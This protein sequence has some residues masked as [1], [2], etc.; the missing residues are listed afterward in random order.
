MTRW[1]ILNILFVAL[2]GLAVA[3]GGDKEDDSKQDTNDTNDT[4]AGHD[5]AKHDTDK[6]D[7]ADNDAFAGLSAEDAKLAKAQK[8]CPVSG[9]ELGSMGA[10]I[11]VTVKDRTV[12]LCCDMCRKKI[13]AEPDK[14]LAKLDK[15]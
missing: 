6:G 13:V 9:E 10:P 14:Y 12:F 7:D 15:K 4:H 11:K 2:T 3:C 8:T 5:H 1:K